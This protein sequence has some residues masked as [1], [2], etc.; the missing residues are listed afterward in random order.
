MIKKYRRFSR[1]CSI[2]FSRQH[3][4]AFQG[5][6]LPIYY[7]MPSLNFLFMSLISVKLRFHSIPLRLQYIRR[8][9]CKGFPWKPELE[10][11]N[12]KVLLWNLSRE[13][14]IIMYIPVTLM[15]FRADTFVSDYRWS[16]LTSNDY[17]LLMLVLFAGLCPVC[18]KASENHLPSYSGAALNFEARGSILRRI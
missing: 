3:L 8:F 16:D 2:V 9:Q 11:V 17:S 4:S 10:P 1:H 12:V 14:I 5:R 7:V 15:E 13:F 18:T 6:N